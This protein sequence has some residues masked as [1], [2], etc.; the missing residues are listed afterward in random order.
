MIICAGQIAQWMIG[1][2]KALKRCQRIRRADACMHW[3][4]GFALGLMLDGRIV[5]G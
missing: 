3:L 5:R 4:V 2:R 1:F